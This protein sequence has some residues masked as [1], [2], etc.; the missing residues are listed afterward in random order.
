MSW[1]VSD[2]ELSLTLSSSVVSSYRYIV[3][4]FMF[5]FSDAMQGMS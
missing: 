1:L 4:G 3:M 5:L 2:S